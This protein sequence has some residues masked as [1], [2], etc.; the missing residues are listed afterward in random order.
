MPLT[1]P[2]NGY[3]EMMGAKGVSA[4]DATAHYA[5][6]AKMVEAFTAT[7]AGASMPMFGAVDVGSDTYWWDY[8]PLGC[9]RQPPHLHT[10]Q[11]VQHDAR[12][13]CATRA[14]VQAS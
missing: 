2:E 3:V 9:V 5:R 12:N 1:L 14:R 13:A 8:G 6:M 4:E 10:T 11:A 7:E